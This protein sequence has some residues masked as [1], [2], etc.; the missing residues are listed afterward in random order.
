[1][2]LLEIFI[3]SLVEGVTEFIPISS[4]GH[5]VLASKLL[6]LV[7]TNFIKTFL[8]VIQFGAILAVVVLYF[9]SFFSFTVLKKLFVAFIP[10]G[11]VGYKLYPII[12][13]SLI[14]NSGLT[15]QA[16]FWGGVLL[17]VIE[18]F[19]KQKKS[20]ASMLKEVT[21][22]QALL[23]GVFQSFSVVP[24]VSRSAATIVGG[25]LSGLNRQTAAEFSFLL[26]VPTMFAAASFDVWSTRNEIVQ[27]GMLSL[28]L[29]TTLSFIFALFAI[30]FLVSYVQKHDFKI[31]GLYRIILAILFWLV[32][33]K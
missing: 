31:F 24:G 21:Y 8:V 28:F 15:L 32:V 3:L 33:M 23:I 16:L 18:S 22:S 11:F 29:G 25:L 13:H 19:I 12:K 26:A 20:N 2:G 7:E 1:M 9:K 5:L 10:A 30:K 4:T 6:G 27:G 14:G 17:I